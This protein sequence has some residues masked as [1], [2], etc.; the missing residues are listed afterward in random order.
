M[1]MICNYYACLAYKYT[2]WFVAKCLKQ[3]DCYNCTPKVL[4][5]YTFCLQEVHHSLANELTRR[6]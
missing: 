4:Q 2:G 5:T 3:S 1:M 6:T